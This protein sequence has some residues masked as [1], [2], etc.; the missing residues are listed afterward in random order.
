MAKKRRKQEQEKEEKEYKPPRFD[1]REFMETEVGV[2]KGTIIAVIIAVPMAVVAFF[3][4]ALSVAGGLLIGL[5]GIGL[6][7][8]LLPMLGIEVTRYKVTHWLGVI[9]SYF[10]LFLA[11]WVVLCNPPFSDRAAPD[12]KNV[13]VSW[14][15]LKSVDNETIYEDV[16][17]TE[18]EPF[19]VQ[20]D[21]ANITSCRLFLSSNSGWNELV[22][23]T[24]YSLD[25]TTGR[26]D[27]SDSLPF[28][29]NWEFHARYNYSEFGA[30]LVTEGTAEVPSD[31]HI[32]YTVRAKVTD[33]VQVFRD[34]IKLS[35]N[36]QD[37]ADRR[38]MSDSDE[39]YYY[40]Y[41]FNLNEV[42]TGDVIRLYATDVNG[43][44]GEVS[45]PLI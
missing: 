43:H 8:F 32:I 25:F 24:D 40:E 41:T 21:N 11:I 28:S 10:F 20:L 7:W 42:H 34:S 37:V 1:R 31:T 27:L 2:A 18:S 23:G 39:E 26:I 36:S 13:S 35:L 29:S 14:E 45:F 12:I 15:I 22:R 16:T 38:D 17:G 6:I 30:L 33:N 19:Y 9:S 3:V 44:I 5:V 4:M